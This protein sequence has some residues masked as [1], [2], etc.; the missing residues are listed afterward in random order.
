MKLLTFGVGEVDKDAVLQPGQAQI[1]RVKAASQQ[2]V[3]EIL[4]I[5]GSL[6]GGGVKTPR[7]GLV[8]EVINEV[9]ELAA[10]LGYFSNHGVG[11]WDGGAAEPPRGV[12][13]GTGP[14][15]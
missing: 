7:L 5:V 1:D 15:G 3:L 10:G 4:D 6:V 2:V 14:W 8:K 13:V 11:R 9:N 12:R